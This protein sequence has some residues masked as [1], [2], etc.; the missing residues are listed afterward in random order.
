VGL[1]AGLPRQPASA[2]TALAD[3]GLYK[4]ATQV[5][6][7]RP[8][9]QIRHTRGPRAQVLPQ[10][11]RM[12]AGA[13][14]MHSAAGRRLAARTPAQQRHAAARARSQAACL[15]GGPRVHGDATPRHAGVFFVPAFSGLLAPHWRADARGAIL[16]LTGSTCAA[17]VARALLEA[18]AW[19]ARPRPGPTGAGSARL[20]AE[21]RLAAPRTPVR[22]CVQ[23]REC[24]ARH[25]WDVSGYTHFV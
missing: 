1:T 21:R 3:R 10:G 15:P 5:S 22:H 20:P 4:P 14:C 12:P 23:L 19:Q 17:H 9:V 25:R 13:C 6:G 16:G 8:L 24:S 11:A 7:A 2:C 18:L